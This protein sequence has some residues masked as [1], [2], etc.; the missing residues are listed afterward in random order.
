MNKL[1]KLPSSGFRFHAAPL[2]VRAFGTFPVLM[3]CWA[4][5]QVVG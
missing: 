3:Q 2:K 5:K 1:E 4:Q